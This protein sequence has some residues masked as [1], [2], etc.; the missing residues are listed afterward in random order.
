MRAQRERCGARIELVMLVRSHAECTPVVCMGRRVPLHAFHQR[1]RQKG[2]GRERE[3]ER[4]GDLESQRKDFDSCGTQTGRRSRMK[5][6]ERGE[7]MF[8]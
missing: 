5:C 1:E 2:R 3:R 4:R 6:T 8:A 7:K